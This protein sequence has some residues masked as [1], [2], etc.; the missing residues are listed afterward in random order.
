MKALDQSRLASKDV[1]VFD[2]DG[3]ILDSMNVK[4]E[5]FGKALIAALGQV[6]SILSQQEVTTLY[7]E[8]SGR[9]RREIFIEI[10]RRHGIEQGDTDFADF[11]RNFSE[12]NIAAM[13]SVSLF[14][15]AVQ[16]LKYLAMRKKKI[17]ISSSVPPTELSM[18]VST[19]IPENLFRSFSGILGSSKSFTKGAAH[20][21]RI[22]KLANVAKEAIIVFGDD[23][24]DY[25]LAYDSGVDCL[26][27][28]RDGRFDPTAIPTIRSFLDIYELISNEIPSD[29]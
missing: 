23:L 8:L 17:F 5:N 28:D 18:I 26:L 2:W 1:Y 10:L 12:M 4:G 14:A 22:E 13:K 15:D 6:R 25:A 29:S 16:F 19:C 20:L 24:A 21:Q 27:I 11:N 7:L 9:S 3:T